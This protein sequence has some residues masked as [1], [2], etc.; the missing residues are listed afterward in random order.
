MKVIFPSTGLDLICGSSA[1]GVFVHAERRS[2]VQARLG[3]TA[4]TR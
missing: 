1:A 2:S 4:G 3:E